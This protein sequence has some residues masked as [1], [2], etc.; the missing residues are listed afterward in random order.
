MKK[1]NTTK[2]KTQILLLLFIIAV[3]PL[4]FSLIPK[5]LNITSIDNTENDDFVDYENLR[6]NLPTTNYI[7]WNDAWEFRI[8]MEIS[9]TG[10]QQNAP[11]E[12]LINFTKYFVDL[13]INNPVLNIST[14]RVIEYTSI[15]DFN[16]IPCQFDPWPRSY[17][18]K[19]NAIGDLI[20]ILNGT[21]SIGETREFFIYFNNGT[22]SEISDPGYDTIRLWHQGFEDNF[23]SGYYPSGELYRA[24]DGQDSYPTSENW[25]ISDTVSARGDHSFN[26]TGNCWKSLYTGSITLQSDTVLTAKMRFDDPSILREISGIGFR[27]ISTSIPSSEN[28]YNIR[29]NQ[30]WGLTTYRNLYYSDNTFFHYTFDIITDTYLIA[31]IQQFYIWLV[32]DDDS[33]SEVDLFWDDI[34]I[35]KHS[36]QTTP[37]SILQP[38][39]GDVEPASFTLRI[40][41]KDEDGIGVP[42]AHIYLTNNSQPSVNQDHLTNEDGEWIFVDMVREGIYNI[43]VNYTQ[44]GLSNPKTETVFSYQNYQLTELNEEI[45]ISL[46]LRKMDFVVTDKDN[47]PITYGYVKVLNGS[48]VVGM[49]YLDSLGEG[50]IRW[51]NQ[52]NYNYEVYYDYDLRPEASSY[53]NSQLLVYSGSIGLPGIYT[54]QALITKANF[55][56]VDENKDPYE[57]A[58]LSFYNQTGYDGDHSDILANVTVDE[59][60]KAQ[61]V[62]FNNEVGTWGTYQM[63]VYSRKSQKSF[64]WT[65]DTSFSLNKSFILTTTSAIDVEG[66][67]SRDI[68]KS[69]ITLIA[70]NPVNLDTV[71]ILWGDTFLISFN[72]TTRYTSNPPELASPTDIWFQIKND[73][74]IAI[75]SKISLKGLDS[76][77]G[78]FSYT[79]NTSQISLLEGNYFW[80]EITGKLIGYSLPDPM[81]QRLHVRPI[82]TNLTVHNYDTLLELM[83]NKLS[84]NYG[85][86]V[87]ITVRYTNNLGVPLKGATINYNWKFGSDV[88]N[89]DPMNNDF[90]YFEIDTMD[91]D[92]AG[93]YRIDINAEIEN[94]ENQEL[95]MDLIIL[96]IPTSLNGTKTAWTPFSKEIWIQEESY[97][98][99]DYRNNLSD[100]PI[101]D[102]DEGASY[103]WNKKDEG[104][105]PLTGPGNEGSGFLT[106]TIDHQYKLD[107]DTEIREVGDYALF[108]TLQKEN[109][110]IRFGFIDLTIKKREINLTNIPTK[111][112]GVQGNPIIISLTLNDLSNDN[113]LL[114]GADV[115]IRVNNH[116]Y[117]FTE[118][119]PG[120]YR[121]SF[122][123]GSIDALFTPQTLIGHI[124]I[125][126]ADYISQ[127]VPITIVVEMTE[128]W[129]GMPLFYFL[130]IIGAVVLVVGSLT[131][132]R[133]IQQRRIPTFVKKARDMRS[134]IKG[135]KSISD[136]LLY[137]SKE[138]Y[139]IKRLGDKWEMLGLSLGDIL[140]VKR[141]KGKQLPEPSE[142]EGGGL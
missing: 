95:T 126:K 63:E 134:N 56:V 128:I 125:T 29:G 44:N 71:G 129:P 77:A 60:G 27:D 32:A 66:V 25:K 48:D 42:N 43:T 49:V 140:G 142:F 33:Y 135:K 110:E 47:Y 133:V 23:P 58:V 4:M 106:E 2:K 59:N 109:Y 99:F 97:L 87:N 104:G 116:K 84:V 130:L 15:S 51:I 46:S 28:S 139:I 137:P 34:S 102:L 121:C 41:C 78:I 117:N 124:N 67:D 127:E 131:S 122:P 141:K 40:E 89:E 21:T 100:Q 53:K 76:P 70:T 26:I 14:I 118:Y 20:W 19:T 1:L 93:Q 8:P 57:N 22:N 138:E 68:L 6:T 120:K 62:S 82:S 98:Y 55:T 7:W 115:F 74:N 12:L 96:L 81:R 30:G 24:T 36:V 38:T 90:Y 69:N 11:V 86:V 80:I 17:D 75:I 85:E 114:E 65:G 18:N 107:F 79:Y 94:Y 37:G 54:P 112:T 13:D 31:G 73:E 88:I 123:T 132:Y 92:G 9:S 64:N 61:F 91:T 72:F 39:L 52:T 83:D 108:V 35:W 111:L 10:Q 103:Y 136:S 5:I 16:E 101:T 119:E 105:D 45:E 113:A 50:T 3:I